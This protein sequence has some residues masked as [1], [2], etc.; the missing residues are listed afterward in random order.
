MESF[1]IAIFA[2]LVLLFLWNLALSFLFER[3]QR[4]QKTLFLGKR[5]KDLEEIIFEILKNQKESQKEIEEIKDSIKK[6]KPILQNSI[7][8]VGIVRFNPFSNMGGN[9]SFSVAF[10][11]QKDN[12]VVITSYHSKEGTRVYAKPI[13]Q[14]HSE[15]PLTQEEKEAIKK[16]IYKK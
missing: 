15:F 5:A 8:K 7:Q 12:G 6:L 4:R 9:Q 2:I 16:A 3:V 13:N 1:L 14:G 11:D 10:L